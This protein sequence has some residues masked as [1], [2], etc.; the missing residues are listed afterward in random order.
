[1][2]NAD[3]REHRKEGNEQLLKRACLPTLKNRRLQDICTLI[4]KDKHKLCSDAILNLFNLHNSSYT[5]NL[6]N[7]EFFTPRFNTVKFGK[8]SL[9]Y[10]GPVLWN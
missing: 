6:K 5:C 2:I 9:R 7:P 1:M 8:H 10:S 4:Y 3:W